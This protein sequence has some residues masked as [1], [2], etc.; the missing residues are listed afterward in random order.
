MSYFYLFLICT[1]L[2]IS[3]SKEDKNQQPLQKSGE[4]ETTVDTNLT[5]QEKF[6]SSMLIDFMDESDDAELAD[7]LETEIYRMGAEFTG[8]SIV[9]I[10]PAVWFIMLEKDGISKNYLLQ[11]FVNFKSNEYYF[12]LK[13]T[14]LTITD[15]VTKRKVNTSAGE[16]SEP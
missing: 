13:E 7:Y 2:F 15:I 6:S 10:S 16:M 1:I 3:C 11:K 9:E 14:Y 8:A 5:P 4:T 12:T